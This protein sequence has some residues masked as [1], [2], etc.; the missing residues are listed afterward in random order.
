MPARHVFGVPVHDRTIPSYAS[1]V[2]AFFLKTSH[3]CEHRI[4][5]TPNGRNYTMVSK[6]HPDEP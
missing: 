5:A 1:S 4:R 3:C 6:R 2:H